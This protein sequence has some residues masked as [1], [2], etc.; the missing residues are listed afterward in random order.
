MYHN[1]FDSHLHSDNSPDAYH[2]VMYLAER[3]QSIGLMGIA[4]TDHADCGA[5]REPDCITRMIQSIVDVAKAAAAFRHRMSFS[6]GMEVGVNGDPEFADQLVSSYPFDYVLGSVHALKSGVDLYRVPYGSNTPEQNH[7]IL[8][9]Y[10][11]QMLEVVRW[12]GFDSLA[13]MT[14]PLRSAIYNKVV[15]DLE[16]Y[17]ERIDAILRG[18][19]QQGKALEI[20]TS[21]LRSP[22]KETMP[23][24]WI[25]RRF[26]EL[27]GEYVTIGSDAHRVEHVGAGLQD[28]MELIQ[29]TGFEFFAFY[30]KRRPIMLR[31]V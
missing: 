22:L 18:L 27:G 3:A 26:R 15:I 29:Q 14:Y 16:P 19:V 20:N 30:R 17:R 7:A 2:S 8:T 25:L 23:S 13:H 12:G 6:I 24:P 4:I 11:D 28:A 5:Q 1:L 9:A 21:G 10:F 31:I